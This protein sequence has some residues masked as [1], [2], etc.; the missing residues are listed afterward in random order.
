[1]VKLG[2]RI[3]QAIATLDE[4]A[5]LDHPFRVT[6]P[7]GMEEW[8]SCEK[9]ESPTR[10]VIRV[11]HKLPDDW[12]LYTLVHEWAHA[13]SWSDDPLVENH[14]AEWGV[15]YARCYQAIFDP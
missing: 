9:L 1:M 6:R 13:L 7:K 2:K 14:G 3:K 12:A 4:F 10:F 5:A 8:G 15:A 11:H